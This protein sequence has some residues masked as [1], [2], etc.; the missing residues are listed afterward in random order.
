[1]T[2]TSSLQTLFEA[3]P[4]KKLGVLATHQTTNTLKFSTA[5]QQGSNCL[6]K[7]K[8]CFFED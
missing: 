1:M 7:L 8:S 4:L 3:T 2:H 6:S 5:I